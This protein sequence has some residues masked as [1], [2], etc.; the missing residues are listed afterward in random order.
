MWW[1][2]GWTTSDKYCPWLISHS[3]NGGIAYPYLYHQHWTTILLTR[4]IVQDLGSNMIE[5]DSWAFPGCSLWSYGGLWGD[6]LLS[7]VVYDSYSTHEM[8]G[9]HIHTWV[10]VLRPLQH[11]WGSSFKFFTPKP[12]VTAEHVWGVVWGHGV[13][14]RVIHPCQT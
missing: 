6:P 5:G 14:C 11:W 1:S 7:D 2:V 12:R 9:Y 10:A 13:V 4:S 8:A 3:W